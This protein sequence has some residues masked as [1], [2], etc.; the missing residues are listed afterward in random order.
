VPKDAQFSIRRNDMHR[1]RQHPCNLEVLIDWNGNQAP[2][3][4]LFGSGEQL[5]VTSWS[6]G[7]TTVISISK[8]CAIRLL[9]H[10]QRTTIVASN[11]V[12]M[13]MDRTAC[14]RYVD[15]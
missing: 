12:Q 14:R 2:I 11:G 4:L 6:R 3:D 10:R 9:I 13:V 5:I 15:G 8:G 7:D 1:S